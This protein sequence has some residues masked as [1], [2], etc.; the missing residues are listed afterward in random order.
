MRVGRPRLH[1]SDVD[2]RTGIVNE[3]SAQRNERVLHPKTEAIR[4]IEYKQ[5]ALVGGHLPSMHQTDR[6]LIA[7]GGDL[8]DD[9][10]HTRRQLHA[11]EV[12][13]WRVSVRY[14]MHSGCC[15]KAKQELIRNGF[16]FSGGGHG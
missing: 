15:Q 11:F 4:L 10:V 7:I 9:A 2:D 8:R 3:S 1:V 13:L 16:D 5:H 6:S 14:T 12:K